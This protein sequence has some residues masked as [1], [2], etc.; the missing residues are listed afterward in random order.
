MENLEKKVRELLVQNNWSCN[1]AGRKFVADRVELPKPHCQSIRWMAVLNAAEEVGGCKPG[2]T[3]AYID[4]RGEKAVACVYGLYDIPGDLTNPFI[5][6]FSGMMTAHLYTM[7]AV[8]FYAQK[9]KSLLPLFCTGKEGN[10]GLFKEVFDRTN[11]LMVQT[12]AEAYMRPLSVLAPEK[13]VRRYERAVADTDTHGNFDEMYA[14]AKSLGLKEA[15][16]LL[17]SGNFSYDK[18]LLA[19]GMLQLRDKKY[20]DVKINLAIIHCPLWVGFSVPEGHI[21]D[22]L[23]GYVAASLG[24]LM[25][26]T[27]PLTLSPEAPKAERYLLPGVAE[28]DWAVFEELITHYSNMG[29]PN[30]QEIL[31]GVNH[32]DAVTNIIMSDLY[33]RASFTPEGYDHALW[34]DLEAYQELIGKYQKGQDFLDF[35][36]NTPDERFFY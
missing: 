36:I 7:E 4:A 10:K 6:C 21:S 5:V 20:A 14:L 3:Y 29:W 28:A 35:L 12:E 19:E 26:D 16:F 2:E 9:H 27:A 32:E 23:L 18:R 1:A 11:G 15:T 31:Y 30:Y 8:R 17:C 13:W 34:D 25:K 22:L 24:P 33:A